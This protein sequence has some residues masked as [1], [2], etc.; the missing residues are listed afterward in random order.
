MVYYA[1]IDS[2]DNASPTHNDVW[3]NSIDPSTGAQV[4]LGLG[5][6]FTNGASAMSVN[7]T[8]G[9]T[10]LV[11]PFYSLDMAMLN[12]NT[13]SANSFNRIMIAAGNRN[14][15]DGVNEGAVM[16]LYSDGTSWA[17]TAGP[18]TDPNVDPTAG[19]YGADVSITT[20]EAQYINSGVTLLYKPGYITVG[21]ADPTQG[22]TLFSGI[23]GSY[24]I[25][26]VDLTS[27]FS[28]FSSLTTDDTVASDV[29]PVCLLY[30]S[31][32]PRDRG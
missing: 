6:R 7:N 1:S 13:S 2:R 10:S 5:E 32:S 17:G 12:Y 20:T 15:S 27:S 19:G 3:L 31:P 23:T 28:T 14:Y 11:S 18:F 16:F 30:T 24:D 29:R 8:V 26:L 22:N 21:R 4:N 25:Y 9:N